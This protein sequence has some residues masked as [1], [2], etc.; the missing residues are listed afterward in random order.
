MCITNRRQTLSIAADRWRIWWLVWLVTARLAMAQVAVISSFSPVSGPPG[1]EVTITGS[2]FSTVT[3]LRFNDAIADFTAAS[4]SQIIAIVPAAATSGR[5]AAVNP[6]GTANSSVNFT[7]PPRIDDFSPPLGAAGTPVVINGANFTNAT[8]VRFNGTAATFAVTAERQISATVPVGATDGP[9]TV[10]TT[11][12]SVD[13]VTNFVASSRPIIT[14]VSPL[15]ATAGT[16]IVINGANFTG[17][18]TVRF[19]GVAAASVSATGQGTQLSVIVPVGATTGP[20]T[21]TTVGGSATNSQPFI[22][23]TQPVVTDFFP[24]LGAVGE[25]ITING[26]NFQGATAVRFN[27]VAAAVS[28]LSATSIQAFVPTGATTGPI[29]VTTPTGTGASTTN[30]IT[31]PAPIITGFDPVVGAVNSQ[32]VLS[33]L[34]FATSGLIVRF[35][36]VAATSATATAPGQILA[37][38]PSTATTGPLTVTTSAGT[39]VTTSNFF[40]SGAAPFVLG[41]TPTNGPRSTSLTI[42]GINFTLANAVRFNGVLAPGATATA[43]SQMLVPVPPGALTGPISITSPSGT[44]TSAALFYA[45]PRFTSVTPASGVAGTGITITGTNFTGATS[46]TFASTNGTRLA[47]PFSVTASNQ[48]TATVP[49]NALTGP[50]V[51]TT[52]G[53]VIASPAA[54]PVLPRLDTFTPVL[55]PAGT[56]VILQGQNFSGAT[57]VRF[58]GSAAAFTVNSSTQI[59]ATV[60]A[61][62]TTGIL[63]IA[64]ADGSTSSANT[65][66]VTRPTDLAIAQ[67][68]APA[69]FLVSQPATFYFT[70]TNKGPSTVTGVTVQ[71]IFPVGMQFISATS[72]VGTCSFGSGRLTCNLGTFT[73]NATA[74][75]TLTVLNTIAGVPFHQVSVTCN[76]GDTRAADNLSQAFVAVVSTSQRTLTTRLIDG[77]TDVEILWPLVLAPTTLLLQSTPYLA[78]NPPWTNVNLTPGRVTNNSI[79]YNSITQ[80]ASAGPYFF[81]LRTP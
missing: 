65:F 12:G 20:L 36:G 1:T 39:S 58:N 51:I 70:V 5:L 47:V 29:S 41:F 62:A 55:G 48:L 44:G 76:E 24:V 80:N 21:I 66:L 63:E 6:S 79:V 69:V 42:T 59:T 18:L 81:R 67:S 9:I 50:L 43:D 8:A 75:I 72:T 78:P 23:G 40:V 64:N 68:N 15:A 4:A 46:L 35:N 11:A 71:D 3:Q 22:T 26:L 25:A 19:N 77:T 33:G 16:A 34:N 27:G 57:A 10:V 2:G 37:R 38:V 45:P 7:V 28:A 61:G 32:I 49:T 30:F 17:T 53:G 31:G 54:F 14:E 74:T 52:P 73:N 60:P 56:S 13:S